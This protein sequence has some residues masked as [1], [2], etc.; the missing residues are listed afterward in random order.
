MVLLLLIFSSGN[1]WE[2]VC[3][4]TERVGP[5]IGV[6]TYQTSVFYS[7]GIY[8]IHTT[9]RCG[10]EHSFTPTGVQSFEQMKIHVD[11][12]W[13]LVISTYILV[14][15]VFEMTLFRGLKRVNNGWFLYL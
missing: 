10:P 5:F 6:T 2:L 13:L 1:S 9:T 3:T 15:Q 7:L 14:Q 4:I 8:F 11:D 12:C